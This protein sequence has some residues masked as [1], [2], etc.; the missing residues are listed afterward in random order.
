[1]S[2]QHYF[3]QRA[4]NII[5]A[6]TKD[7]FWERMFQKHK[8]FSAYLASPCGQ[9][10]SKQQIEPSPRSTARRHNTE[11][12]GHNKENQKNA[13]SFYQTLC[14]V[15]GG[16]STSGEIAHAMKDVALKVCNLCLFAAFQ[17]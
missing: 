14:S 11:N 17:D 4:Q 10:Q 1:M 15:A 13:C 9:S 5:V 12:Q 7:I 16:Q 3:E 6:S 8:T 2:M